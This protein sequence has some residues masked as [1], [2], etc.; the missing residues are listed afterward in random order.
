[1]KKTCLSLVMLALVAL[2]AL[3]GAAQDA[4]IELRIAWYNDGN[5]G[6]VLRE[7][8]DLFQAENPDI[9][10]VVDTIGYENLDTTLQPQ[11][12][13]G[14]APDLARV[15]DI[16]RYKGHYLNLRPYL[17]DPDAWAANW[18]PGVLEWF[19]ESGDTDG[20]YGYMTQA[21]VTGPF[22]NR[23][24]FE[25]AGI[26]VPSD[27]QA[28]VTWAEWTAAA[29]QVAQ[30]LSTA[31]YPIFAVAIDRSGHRVWGPALSM[32]ATFVQYDAAG[33][34]IRD[35]AGNV[36]F[37]VDSPGFRE[38]AQMIIDWHRQGLTSPEIWVGSGGQYASG[39][40]LFISGRLVMLMSG[41][42]QVGAFSGQIGD[43]FDWEAVPNPCGPGGCTGI[44][45]G[46]AL[47]AFKDTDHPEAVAR[48]VEFLTTEDN[49]REFAEKTLFVPA[50]LRLAA[51]GV[52][53]QTDLAAAKESLNVFS[54]Q[55]SLLT[56]EAWILQ[57]A[58]NSFTLNIAIRE[59]LT[60]AITGELTLDEAIARIQEEVDEGLVED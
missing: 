7:Q 33:N 3:P 48:L 38:T 55:V 41:S 29:S 9:Q 40:D 12:E 58:P 59:R 47:M 54:A 23:T 18:S 53:F 43:L 8:L 2:S 19:R 45:G 24:L 14:N 51:S 31:D 27:Q 21:T 5:E 57:T 60:Q 49:L 39:R 17:T 56:D 52:D 11:V 44:P 4:V 20:L 28:E 15:T 36:K 26:A 16:A 22:I 50:D 13:T 6:D 34:V 25:Q 32:G 30:A 37:Q 42:F 10:V 35:S 1:M 46:A